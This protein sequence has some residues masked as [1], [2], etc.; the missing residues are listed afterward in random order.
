MSSAEEDPRNITNRCPLHSRNG[1]YCSS[2]FFRG[3]GVAERGDIFMDINMTFSGLRPSNVRCVDVVTPIC[4]QTS[5]QPGPTAAI[6]II[7]LL[8]F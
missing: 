7:R 3:H 4:V 8:Q 6:K 5:A 1:M 2:L